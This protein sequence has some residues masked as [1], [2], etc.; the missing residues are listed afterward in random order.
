MGRKKRLSK[1]YPALT[2]QERSDLVLQAWKD[3]TEQDPEILASMP[4]SQAAEFHGYMT[5]MNGANR[6]L[7]P[8]VMYTSAKVDQLMLGFAWLNS[9]TALMR[10]ILATNV[11]AIRLLGEPITA[12]EYESLAKK[13]SNTVRPEWAPHYD[14]HT[15]SH[16]DVVNEFRESFEAAREAARHL[17]AVGVNG[18]D[19]DEFQAIIDLPATLKANIR[20]G[21]ELIWPRMRALEEVVQE[22][23]HQ[24][25]GTDPLIPELRQDL[26][27]TR[28]Q[29]TMLHDQLGQGGDSL[30]LREPDAAAIRVMRRMAQMDVSSGDPS[31]T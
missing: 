13:E 29:L 7:G 17:E 28:S 6:H 27:D 8:P 4:R 10:V 26:D 23:A 18:I 15:D 30:E 14:V 25:G 9:I 12:S 2:A 5:S 20:Q 19:K 16:A 31:H 3:G 22:L 21:I 24:L 11:E 1:V